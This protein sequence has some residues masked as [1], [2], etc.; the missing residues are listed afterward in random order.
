MTGQIRVG[1]AKLNKHKHL[2]EVCGSLQ[3]DTTPTQLVTFD[4]AAFIPPV[5]E[6]PHY[7]SPPSK[8][9]SRM[10]FSSSLPSRGSSRGS[11]LVRHLIIR[12]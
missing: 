8:A 12:R 10:A 3:A 11:L 6:P 4:E 7:P 9:S 5:T 1:T 2:G